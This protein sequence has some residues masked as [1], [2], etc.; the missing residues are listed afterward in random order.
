[1][2]N[3]LIESLQ[4]TGSAKPLMIALHKNARTTRAVRSEIAAGPALWRYRADAAEVRCLVQPPTA[5]VD[6]QEQDTDTG[7]ERV[8]SGAPAF[9]L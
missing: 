3:Q 6:A 5:A 1:M 7:C 2:L 8:V 4:T 9:V